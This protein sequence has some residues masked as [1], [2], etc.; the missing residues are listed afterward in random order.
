MAASGMTLD[1]IGVALGGISGKAV[2]FRL[3]ARGITKPPVCR[4]AKDATHAVALYVAGV[5]IADIAEACAM[6]V[7][8]VRRAARDAGYPPRRAADRLRSISLHDYR[9]QQLSARMAE[10]ASIEQRQ[11]KLAEMWDQPGHQRSGKRAA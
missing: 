1:E 8:T 5:I 7:E 11:I 10:T 9:Q 2:S 6:T 3:R 4:H